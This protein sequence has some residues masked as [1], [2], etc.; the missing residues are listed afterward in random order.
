[1]QTLYSAT[2]TF[3]MHEADDEFHALDQVIARAAKSIPGYLGEEAWENPSTGLISNVY[4]WESMEALQALMTHPAHV[5]A[6]QRQAAWLDG[7]QVVIAQIV[8]CY[9][10]GRI[11]HP[12]QR[13]GELATRA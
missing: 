13:L 7:Y 8:R 3:A 10:D 1:M 12:L 5:E 4:Y 2:F 9:G 6:K 11:A